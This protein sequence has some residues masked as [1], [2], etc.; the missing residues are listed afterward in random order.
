LSFIRNGANLHSGITSLNST[1][2]GTA[3]VRKILEL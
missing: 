2:L 3:T 1:T